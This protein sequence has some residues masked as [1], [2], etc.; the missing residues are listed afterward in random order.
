MSYTQLILDTKYNFNDHLQP[1]EKFCF[2]R[3]PYNVIE[4]FCH[5]FNLII[6]SMVSLFKIYVKRSRTDLFCFLFEKFQEI[7]L[8]VCMSVFDKIQSF[9]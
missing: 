2:F 5:T 6:S 3:M 4:L 1:L 8:S 9:P 7:L